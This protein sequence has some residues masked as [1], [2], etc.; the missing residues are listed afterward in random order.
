MGVNL[1]RL[2]AERVAQGLTQAELASRLGWSRNKYA[3]REN[4]FVSLSANELASIS[5]ALGYSADRIGIFFEATAP[6]REQL[7]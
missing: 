2:K 4:G 3:K 6:K 7:V 1:K 5:N